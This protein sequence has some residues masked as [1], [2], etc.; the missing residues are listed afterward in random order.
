MTSLLHPTSTASTSTATSSYGASTTSSTLGANSYE[1]LIG[2]DIRDANDY[3]VG[4]VDHY[5]LDP[6]NGR[7]AFFGVKTGWFTNENTLIPA[8]TA[9]V[10]YAKRTIRVPFMKDMIKNG[11]RVKGSDEAIITSEEEVYRHYGL[12]DSYQLQQSQRLKTAPLATNLQ[13]SKRETRARNVPVAEVQQGVTSMKLHEEKMGMQKTQVGAGGVRLRKVVRTE[14]VSQPVELKHEE[15]TLQRMPATGAVAPDA[16]EEKDIFVPLFREEAMMY[17]TPYVTEEVRL[18]KQSF[19][20]QR[21]MSGQLRHEDVIVERD[22]AST[23]VAT[24]VASTGLATESGTSY[25][26]TSTGLGTAKTQRTG[27]SGT[28]LGSSNVEPSRRI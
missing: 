26:A 21:E 5:W 16:F 9:Q 10:N 13:E 17:K 11:P 28:N 27:V 2:F 22:V 20:E 24:N 12:W 6:D 23:G 14:N 1:R 7:P 19:T 8:H 15:A 25:G 18:G 3:S 4:K